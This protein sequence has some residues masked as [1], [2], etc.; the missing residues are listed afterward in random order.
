MELWMYSW[1]GAIHSFFSLDGL[2][3]AKSLRNDYLN[4][5]IVVDA[6]YHPLSEKGKKK[7]K[8]NEKINWK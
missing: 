2:H 7:I 8:E 1:K 3:E 5:L 6:L 4:L